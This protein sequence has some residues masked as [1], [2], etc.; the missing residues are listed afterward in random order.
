[1]ARA[2]ILDVN[3]LSRDKL[4]SD[5]DLWVTEG[6][7]KSDCLT[8]HGCVVVAINGVGQ[9]QRGGEP[10]PDWDYVK[11]DGRTI[12]ICFDA[13]AQVNYRVGQEMH[14]LGYFLTRQGA[15]V[16]YIVTPGD[17][18]DKTGADDFL[19]A[20]HSLDELIKAATR[21]APK[22][23]RTSANLP[24]TDVYPLLAEHF[25]DKYIWVKGLGW[26][27]WSRSRWKAASDEHVR[28]EAARWVKARWER[29]MDD[30][31]R[32]GTGESIDLA[33][34]W[35][36]YNSKSKIDNVLA[37]AKGVL[38]VDVDRLD[39]DPD[40][41]N[42]ANGTMDLR[43][44][45]LLPHNPQ[46]Y[47]TKTTGIRYVPG[48][49]HRDWKLALTA[50]PDAI[51]R[52]LQVKLGQGVTG[53]TPDDDVIPFAQGVGANG[54]STIFNAIAKALGDYYMV[55]AARALMADPKAHTTE[56]AD[57]RGARFAVLEELPERN[58]SVTRIK[59]LAGGTK[60]TA[61]HIMKDSITFDP[62]HT[63]FVTTNYRPNVPESDH[64]TWRRLALVRF[65]FKF[66]DEPDPEI[67]SQRQGDPGL[68][69]RIASGQDGS[70]FEAV[71]A[72]LIEG[73]RQWYAAG[74]LLPA[75]PQPVVEDT[76]AWRMESDTILRFWN[77]CLEADRDAFLPSAD[78]YY[79]YKHWATENGMRPMADK[80]LFPKLAEHQV[81]ETN[82]VV[83]PVK[84]RVGS[85]D[86]S[87]HND[88]RD[89]EL[90]A[91]VRGWKGIRLKDES[92]Y[93]APYFQ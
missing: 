17:P 82:G 25:E 79:V 69:Q 12:Y 67:P 71:L 31:K 9:W 47:I 36:S 80:T 70:F 14:D 33:K 34:K 60:I 21:E 28:E 76:E 3:P 4:W 75:L 49:E 40:L 27:R 22:V 23:K 20:D 88:L 65:P 50:V 8:S 18:K 55:V 44:G 58:M 73:A 57:F 11:L 51:L 62:T 53:H 15:D 63:L 85:L 13:D 26:F 29:A 54:K 56:L 38:E 93:G 84:T 10:L 46:D 7:K 6:I 19:A 16:W 39:A 35:M 87:R 48:A 64:G 74:Q 1:M 24:E 91:T 86:V 41:L 30:A 32:E 77:D 52:W 90:G 81:A 92:A 68:R 66:V 83:G 78:L 43:T 72:W 89:T 61:R 2:L 59:A 37:L 45:E 5:E 42:C